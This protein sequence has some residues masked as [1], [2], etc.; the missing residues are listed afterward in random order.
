MNILNPE[1]EDEPA[2]TPG[3]LSDVTAPE[4]RCPQVQP[5]SGWHS[6]LGLPWSLGSRTEA[7]AAHRSVA[8]TGPR[9]DRRTTPSASAITTSGTASMR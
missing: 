8:V 5:A 7:T 9:N 3:S 6:T 1:S 4:R 2:V